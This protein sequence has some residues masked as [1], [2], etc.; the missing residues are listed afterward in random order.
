[1]PL[2]SLDLPTVDCAR[3][4]LTPSPLSPAHLQL[5][6]VD[7]HVYNSVTICQIPYTEGSK[8]TKKTVSL[9]SASALGVRVCSLS[10]CGGEEDW[11]GFPGGTF[12]A[13]G[14]YTNSL[15]VLL[16]SA[17]SLP[18]S[19]EHSPSHV[20]ALPST[21]VLSTFTGY[22][23][24][25]DGTFL[26]N[27]V[28]AEGLG[29]I[30]T[31]LNRS[32]RESRSR[33]L[34]KLLDTAGEALPP[35]G[36]PP[37]EGGV[38]ATMDATTFLPSLPS[39]L[40]SPD[41]PV[42]FSAAVPKTGVSMISWAKGGCYVASLSARI[43]NCIWI[44]SITG[45]APAPVRGDGSVPEVE[46]EFAQIGG[47]LSRLLCFRQPVRSFRFSPKRNALA[48]ATGTAR[49]YIF[50]F[51]KGVVYVDLPSVYKGMEVVSVRWGKG[52]EIVAIGKKGC[53]LMRLEE[54]G[55]EEEEEGEEGGEG[56]EGRE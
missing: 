16:T 55:E 2:C 25:V 44:W 11:G 27:E 46:D 38:D 45:T 52:D 10:P 41:A 7:H 20:K 47:G 17:N 9:G 3:A 32:S 22:T 50:T 33:S 49:V 6:A 30:A 34:V 24:T 36:G 26:P 29:S 42:D 23:E 35:P 1:M 31:K 54:E 39:L 56:G 12:V 14:T 15:T 48:V 8:F 4:H 5:V 53:V 51:E 18:Y 28:D 43:P 19:F 21:S 13:F 40:P 37:G